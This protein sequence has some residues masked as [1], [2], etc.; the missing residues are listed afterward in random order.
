MNVIVSLRCLLAVTVSC[1]YEQYCANRRLRI[2]AWYTRALRCAPFY[3]AGFSPLLY[4]LSCACANSMPL[5]P[6][7]C[8]LDN[9]HSATA[10]FCFHDR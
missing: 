9:A 7:F 2:T 5:P 10:C 6:F 8:R 3:A 1:V 4:T